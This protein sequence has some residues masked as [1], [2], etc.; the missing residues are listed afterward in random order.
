MTKRFTVLHVED[1]GEARTNFID[2]VLPPDKFPFDVTQ[3]YA[4]EERLTEEQLTDKVNV[5]LKNITVDFIVIDLALSL[6]QHTILDEWFTKREFPRE[7]PGDLG[8]GIGLAHKLIKRMKYP[9]EKI[10][11]LT[12]HRPNTAFR[13]LNA[14]TTTW[15]DHPI[16]TYYKDSDEELLDLRT[17]IFEA[18]GYVPESEGEKESVSKLS[19]SISQGFPPFVIC[20]SDSKDFRK[21]IERAVQ[22][23]NNEQPPGEK[24]G[25]EII[26]TEKKGPAGF[27][28]AFECFVHHCDQ[29]HC[30]VVI[31][32]TIGSDQNKG[33]EEAAA[34]RKKLERFLEGLPGIRIL[35]KIRD[36]IQAR[37]IGQRTTTIAVSRL[38]HYPR[39]VRYCMEGRLANFVMDESDFNVTFISAIELFRNLYR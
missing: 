6:K 26:D 39:L 14:L 17:E 16:K 24:A 15:W 21:K 36:E 33:L 32:F 25:Q 13:D 29:F 38:G 35:K 4:V 7:P 10:S 1:E 22:L 34:D 28:E 27:E 9:A 11:F 8:G 3:P 18:C 5:I 12:R 30:F 20:A 2:E 23:F 19:T 37:G 31:D